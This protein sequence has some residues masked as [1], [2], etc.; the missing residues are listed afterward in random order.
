MGYPIKYK[1]LDSQRNFL[2]ERRKIKHISAENLS[3]QLGKSKAW[4]GQIERGKLFSIK[5]TSLVDLLSILYDVPKS[6]VINNSILINFLNCNFLN[7]NEINKEEA[8]LEEIKELQEENYQF[9]ELFIKLKELFERKETN[10]MGFSTGD[11]TIFDSPP[12]NPN[13]LYEF[14]DE[15][16]R[17]HMQYVPDWRFGQMFINIFG[18]EDIFYMEETEVLRRV[19]RYFGEE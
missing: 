9:K 3:A 7:Q 6:A 14:Y 18:N 4:L 16:R 11:V 12:R 17:I 8:L 19:K 5:E 10:N 2:R 13:R 1:L 15:F